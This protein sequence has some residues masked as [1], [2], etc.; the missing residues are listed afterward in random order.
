MLFVETIESEIICKPQIESPRRDPNYW[1]ER[2]EQWARHK[3]RLGCDWAGINRTQIE[4]AAFLADLR[5]RAA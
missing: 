4:V 3:A 5:R 1:S 2:R